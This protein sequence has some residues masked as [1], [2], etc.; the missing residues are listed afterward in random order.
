MVPEFHSE[1]GSSVG[2]RLVSPWYIPLMLTQVEVTVL[3][4]EGWTGRHTNVLSKL[5]YYLIFVVTSFQP[6]KAKP[7]WWI[8]FILLNLSF[9]LSCCPINSEINTPAQLCCWWD[10]QRQFSWV[11]LCKSHLLEPHWLS[12]FCFQMLNS[13]VVV[14]VLHTSS[15]WFTNPEFLCGI[16]SAG[17]RHQILHWLS[18]C[19]LFLW[20]YWQ[21]RI[22]SHGQ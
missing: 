15:S 16:S 10:S 1:P 5:D 12:T 22:F 8:C 20:L 18:E 4:A 13:T 9:F 21:I 7:H 6:R 17:H 2:L 3:W 11:C 19:P 14:L